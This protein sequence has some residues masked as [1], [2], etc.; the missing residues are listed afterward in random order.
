MG[1]GEIR[2]RWDREGGGGRERGETKRKKDKNRDNHL[3]TE[4]PISSQKPS[5]PYHTTPSSSLYP[6]P[7]FPFPPCD[8]RS[9]LRVRV[10]AVCVSGGTD[11]I[12]RRRVQMNDYC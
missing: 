12:S 1:G 10:C 9:E 11:G 6:S 7:P 5:T 4:P 8:E 2:V 3:K